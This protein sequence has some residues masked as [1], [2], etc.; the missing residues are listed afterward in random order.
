MFVATANV[1]PVWT[2]SVNTSHS[3]SRQPCGTSCPGERRPAGRGGAAG[4]RDVRDRREQR[5][6]HLVN[7]DDVSCPRMASS[8]TA[9]SVPGGVVAWNW[10]NAS[11]ISRSSSASAA[12]SDT[13]SGGRGPAP[14]RRRGARPCEPDPRPGPRQAPPAARHRP[15]RR[16]PLPARPTGRQDRKRTGRTP[17]QATGL[18]TLH[19]TR[20]SAQSPRSG[21]SQ[22]PNPSFRRPPT[23]RRTVTQ[24]HRW[25]RRGRVSHT[26]GSSTLQRHCVAVVLDLGKS[27]GQP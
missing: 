2:P 23:Q 9:S 17:D 24:R 8:G 22:H 12:P 13:W 11:A 14:A 21:H 7:A 18:D 10:A 19:P 15:G 4:E 3:T 6:Q 5:R 27:T 20:R 25:H 16:P 1:S 26:P